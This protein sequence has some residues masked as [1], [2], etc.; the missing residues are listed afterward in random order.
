M[1]SDYRL[2]LNWSHTSH[3]SNIDHLVPWQTVV[4]IIDDKVVLSLQVEC[5]EVQSSVVVGNRLIRDIAL[6]CD[7]AQSLWQ[8]LWQG[9][10]SIGCEV[11]R[12][13][14][15]IEEEQQT[16]RQLTFKCKISKI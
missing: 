10:G 15:K 11:A 4:S 16:L 13:C 7:N 8:I 12:V 9:D 2:S 3:P 1:V 14:A 6:H 5:G